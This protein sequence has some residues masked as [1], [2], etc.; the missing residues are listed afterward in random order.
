M[1]GGGCFVEA[2]EGGVRSEE[3]EESGE[4]EEELE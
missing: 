4:S 1:A 3:G 2:E